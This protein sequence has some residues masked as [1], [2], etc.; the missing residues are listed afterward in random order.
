MEFQ[1]I[2]FFLKIS[3]K[4][5]FLLG[6]WAFGASSSVFFLESQV[7]LA[8]SQSASWTHCSFGEINHKMCME[9]QEH[10]GYHS[11]WWAFMSKAKLDLVWTKT[12]KI[13]MDIGPSTDPFLVDY[14]NVSYQHSLWF[15]PFKTLLLCGHPEQWRER[16]QLFHIIIIHIKQ[17]KSLIIHLQLLISSYMTSENSTE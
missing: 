3:F 17:L 11:I 1:R 10:L 9:L 8:R 16:M 15:Q 6:W 13:Y 7:S 4:S 5:F 14:P 12:F 2:F